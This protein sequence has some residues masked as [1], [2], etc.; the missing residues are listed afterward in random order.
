MTA[1][2]TRRR[3]LAALIT[4]AAVATALA[5][6]S[7]PSVS[8]TDFPD[9]VSG[10]L[11]GDTTDAITAAV[12]SAIVQSGSSG[13]IVGVW[14]PWA[15]SYTAG[16][17]T[18]EPGGET[19]M[20]PSMVYRIGDTTRPMTCTVLLELVDEGKLKLSDKVQE[21]LPQIQGIEG[22][23]YQQLCQNTAGLGSYTP[24][25]NTQFVTNPTRNWSM[26]EILANGLASGTRTAPGA[27]F[28]SSDTGYILLGMALEEL[29][30]QSWQSLYDHYVYSPLGM[31]KSSFPGATNVDLPGAHPN[32]YT[33]PR[34]PD[35]T[36]QCD[37]P[38]DET[39][40][41]SSM[42]WTAG[43]V[44]S[45]VDD[46][47][48]FTQ[49][50]ASGSLLNDSTYK[51]QWKDPVSLGEDQPAWKTFGIGGIQLGPLRGQ[52]GSIPG[53]LSAAFSDPT[54]GLTVVVM[55]NNSTLGAGFVQA[56]AMQLASIGAKAAPASGQK[57]PEIQLPWSEQQMAEQ[58]A[59]SAMV[60]AAPVAPPAE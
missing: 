45:S 37:V 12:E 22:I 25:L 60:C 13:A 5:G 44:V 17:G 2:A 19:K 47:R 18:T 39:K 9:Q 51:K 57:A 23:T 14:A 52:A 40:L 53:S 48:A 10:A 32:G 31:S 28:G 21:T 46:L 43:G 15:G 58:L 54:S 42:V 33:T 50:F 24:A 8:D 26:A 41:S 29:T 35:G 55:L 16:V 27:L 3:R 59:A 36:Y 4:A 56:L 49:S 7:G 30:G 11:S 34:L 6:C 20:D 38:T 1:P